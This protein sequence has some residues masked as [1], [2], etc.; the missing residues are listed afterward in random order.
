MSVLI[1]E[2]KDTFMDLS[3]SVCFNRNSRNRTR[4]LTIL[5]VFVGSPPPC[6]QMNL[7]L[8]LVDHDDLSTLGPVGAKG[9]DLHGGSHR[10]TVPRPTD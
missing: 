8:S 2:T 1:E 3:L 9:S 10:T 5:F 6:L 4:D 7:L